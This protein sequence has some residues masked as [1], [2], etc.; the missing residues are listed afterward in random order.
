MLKL[1]HGAKNHLVSYRH[2]TYACTAAIGGRDSSYPNSNHPKESQ[3][4]NL[5][6]ARDGKMH[7]Y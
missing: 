5:H 7:S 3:K 1:W 6:A 4:E 2:D